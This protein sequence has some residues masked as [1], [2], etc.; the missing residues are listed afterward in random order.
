MPLGK[1]RQINSFCQIA[2][3]EAARDPVGHVQGLHGRTDAEAEAETLDA[4]INA[5]CS[6]PAFDGLDQI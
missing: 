3:H 1:I 5:R 4:L 6:V 2:A